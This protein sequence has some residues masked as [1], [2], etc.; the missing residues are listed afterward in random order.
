VAEGKPIIFVTV[1]YRV[2][3]FGFLPG[4]EILA[5][6]S[7]NLGLLDQRLG[8]QWV[9]DNIAAFGGDPD[10]VTI[11]GESAGAISVFDQMA[12]YDGNIT[13]KGKPLFRAGIMNSGSVIPAGMYS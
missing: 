7:S 1:N 4:A 5:D 6:G 8:L 13:Y 10:K 12:L 9:A 3:G 11:W 2:A